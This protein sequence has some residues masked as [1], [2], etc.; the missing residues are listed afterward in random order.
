MSLDK[1]QYAGG[2]LFKEFGPGRVLMFSAPGELPPLIS[3][4]PT[5]T[6]FA[7][8]LATKSAWQPAYL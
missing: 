4:S 2:L 7:L 1:G 3:S 6:E 5:H 8:R